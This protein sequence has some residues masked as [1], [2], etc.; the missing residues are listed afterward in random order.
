MDVLA[1][2]L[3]SHF[4]PTPGTKLA[5]LKTLPPSTLTLRQLQRCAA[6]QYGATAAAAKIWSKSK[7]EL[8]ALVND[9]KLEMELWIKRMKHA[10]NNNARI[11]TAEHV[12]LWL[13][14]EGVSAPVIEMLYGMTGERL[15]K[16]RWEDVDG[17]LTTLQTMEVMQLISGLPLKSQPLNELTLPVDPAVL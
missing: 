11:W 15:L 10:M 4:A 5:T 3:R 17:I 16:V 1:H 7:V 9:N 2:R 12:L 8:V 14:A 13:Y 6:S